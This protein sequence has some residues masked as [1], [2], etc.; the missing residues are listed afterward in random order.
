MRPPD[1]IDLFWRCVHAP[2]PVLTEDDLRTV[3]EASRD[4][5]LGTGL[6]RPGPTARSVVCDACA[7]GHVEEVDQRR[8]GDGR[9]RFFIACPESGRVEV[10]PDRLRQWVPDYAQVT[11]MLAS[12]LACSGT[13]DDVVP[14]RLWNVGRATLAGQSRP[15]WLARRVTDDL[16]PLL[17][18]DRLSVLFIMGVMPAAGLHIAADRVFELRRLVTLDGKHL[19]LDA[20]AVQSHTGEVVRAA[21][22]VQR[23]SE[24]R[25]PRVTTIDKLK[26]ALQA[27][28]LARKRALS[29]RWHDSLPAVEQKELARRIGVSQASVYRALHDGDHELEVLAKMVNNPR[30]IMAFRA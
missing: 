18:A 28:I 16:I 23:P 8:C 29:H 12:A 19:C 10:A 17:P 20:A 4:L 24:K 27:E 25:A 6:L 13:C 30:D 14:D 21:A 5:L 26:K 7:G 1:P 2:H 9:T 22:S 3:P 15:V 11:D